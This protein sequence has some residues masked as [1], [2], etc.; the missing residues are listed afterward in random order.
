MNLTFNWLREF[1]DLPAGC[2]GNG[3]EG[4]QDIAKALTMAGIEVESLR[5]S[6][7]DP[8]VVVGL[9]TKV[10]PHPR[11]GHL[12]LCTV[13]IGDEK[14]SVVCGAPNVRVGIKA[15]LVKA[16]TVLPSGTNVQAKTIRGEASDGMLCS[17]M[18]L[19]LSRNHE[20]VMLLP[21]DAPLGAPVFS[22]LGLNDWILEVGVTPNRGDCLGILGL[23]REVA[24][25]TGRRL[26]Y[27][28]STPHS[29]DSS[30]ERIVD[31]E[32]RDPRLCPRY[33]ARM[34]QDL[35]PIS[36]PLYMRFRL[37][38][39]GIRSIN[40]VVDVTNY[41]MLET[42]QPLHAFDVDRLTAKGIIIRP[43]NETKRFLTLDGIERKLAPED[44]LVC[45]GDLPVALAGIMGGLNSEVNR[46]TRSVL[47]E[48]AHFDALTIRRTAKRLG[49]HTEAS[50]RFERGVDPEG[51]LYALDRA[52]F[53]LG[54]ITGGHPIKGIVDRYPQRKRS[55]P[56]LVRDQKV[57][58]LLGVE[59][60]RREIE[61]ILK[62]LGVKIQA[63]SKGG[64]KV[65]IPSYRPDLSREVDLIEEL[66][67]LYGYEKI[68]ATLPMVRTQG[69]LVDPY[70]RWGRRLRSFLIGEGLIE[71]INLP[72]TSREMN[73]RFHGL[74]DD[75]R[76]PVS[77]LNPLKQESSEMR[78]SLIPG[79][80][81]CL[82]SHIGQKVR[83][84]SA[85]ELGKV[86]CLNPN[87]SSEEK[88]NLAALL[89]GHRER[90]G[91]RTRETLFSFL[92]LKGL[93]EGIVELTGAEQGAV[94]TSD[95]MIPFLHPGKA[96]SLKWEG[97]RVG[98]LGE[99]HPDLCEELSLPPLLVF[100][101][102]FGEVVQYARLDLTVR[103]LPRFPSVERDLAVVVDEAFPAQQIINWIKGL[104]HS[105][106]E[107][108]GIF[109]Q[110]R[111]SPI[112][113]GKKSL[114][115]TISYRANDRTLTDEEVNTIHQD[116]TSKMCQ[117]F[118][119]KLRE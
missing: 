64:L 7:Q 67:R 42:G 76:R 75:Q 66:A 111:G 1:T 85:F 49:L 96:A 77:I 112:P 13:E 105:L 45:D 57:K 16:G 6:Y 29:K 58:A 3:E 28:P 48:S 53:L 81:G 52:V 113:E 46:D 19:G 62:C 10:R 54:E 22:Y 97:F 8:G 115:Y 11:A 116:L 63:R 68:P 35:C 80:I 117:V 41:V 114:A 44:L 72:F 119:A 108:V 36:S 102:D 87:G 118:G 51:T 33:S 74:W 110:Y 24:A 78:L 94:W 56:I 86:F 93:V 98:Y 103:A 40:S 47:L 70:L 50:H 99:I 32:I 82:R 60:G 71:V 95:D 14:L 106:I 89:Y 101:L 4:P 91:L 17:E 18:E 61:R 88:T 30:L 31:V 100:E 92:D 27:P 21:E 109:N 15:P 39:C 9:V 20:G 5:P 25:V 59:M 23:A 34:V 55:S 104:K 38:A 26:R 90:R 2:K 79:L 37:E 107:D 12:S 69:G 43:A 83:P 84:F 73:Q 65:L